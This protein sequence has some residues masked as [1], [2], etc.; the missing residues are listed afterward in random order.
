MSGFSRRSFLL[1]AD[2]ALAAPAVVRAESLM[3]L[4]VPPVPKLQV[5]TEWIS[6]GDIMAW[7]YDLQSWVKAEVGRVTGVQM[8]VNGILKLVEDQ[9]LEAMLT[10]S[11]WTRTY[12]TEAA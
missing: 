10:G 6:P 2:T 3:K 7:N 11:S 1:G 12:V 4:W 8:G 5:V 9:V